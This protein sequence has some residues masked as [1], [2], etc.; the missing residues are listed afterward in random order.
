MQPQTKS[1]LKQEFIRNSPSCQNIL[2]C[3]ETFN[4]ILFFQ[5]VKEQGR[6]NRSGHNWRLK[7]LPKAEKLFEKNSLKNI[8]KCRAS[9]EK[10]DA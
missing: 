6:K 3:G 9:E 2:N 8:W 4:G 1:T 7:V 5:A 10:K